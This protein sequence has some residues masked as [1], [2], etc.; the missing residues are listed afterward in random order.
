MLIA[1]F[2]KRVALI[3]TIRAL[4]QTIRV[5]AKNVAVLLVVAP[6]NIDRGAAYHL[7]GRAL[8]AHAIKASMQMV[9]AV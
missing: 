4:A 8:P 5:H 7:L 3:S 9:V 6:L 1:D 2:V